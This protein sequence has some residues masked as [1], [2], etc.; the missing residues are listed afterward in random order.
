MTK[1]TQTNVKLSG[2][3]DKQYKEA[4]FQLLKQKLIV[5]QILAIN[6]KE[7][8]DLSILLCIDQGFEQKE[9]EPPLRVIGS[10]I[11]D[12]LALDLPKQ[13]LNAQTEARK[14]KNIKNEDVGESR[15]SPTA[16]PS[17]MMTPEGFP[18]VIVNTKEYHS[19]CSG[20]Y[21]NDIA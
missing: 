7:D 1:L 12:Y 16:V 19:E 8:E 3:E 15:K 20:K 4:A 14:P 13:I 17:F 21:H 10:L 2:G 5:H 11:H 18:F 6:P 9:R